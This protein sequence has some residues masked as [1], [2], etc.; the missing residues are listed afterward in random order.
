MADKLSALSQFLYSLSR[1]PGLS[2][3]AKFGQSVDQAN[4]LKRNVEAAKQ[5]GKN[6][7]NTR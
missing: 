5:A 2:F 4:A 3:L 1:L 7:S 6:L